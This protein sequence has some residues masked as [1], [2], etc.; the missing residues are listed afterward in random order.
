MC[1]RCGKIGHNSQVFGVVDNQR[2]AESSDIGKSTKV[3]ELAHNNANQINGG[4]SNKADSDSAK[5]KDVD[6]EGDEYGS[7]IHVNYGR[8]KSYYFNKS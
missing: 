3:S 2:K 6:K 4:G 5:D 8:K 7:W 1:F